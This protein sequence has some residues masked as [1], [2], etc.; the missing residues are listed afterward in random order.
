MLILYSLIL[1]ISFMIATDKV[2][3]VSLILIPKTDSPRGP[4]ALPS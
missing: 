1:H 3:H 2:R 4:S